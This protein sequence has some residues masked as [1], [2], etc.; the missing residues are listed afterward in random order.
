MVNLLTNAAKYTDPGGTVSVRLA[1]EVA[2]GAAEG[3]GSAEAVLRVRDSGRG[4]PRDM[5]ERVFDLFVQV[6]PTMDR[7]TG[8]LGLGLTLVKRMVELHGGTV[9]AHSE[10]PGKGSEF[11][12]RLSLAT[13]ADQ[14]MPSIDPL[15]VSF[16]T[17]VA[18]SL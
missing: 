15:P 2:G 10:G 5:L 4:I 6:N 3:G 8:G 14:P 11:V 12:V 1:R 9:S 13:N 16:P 18:S 7:N 17:S